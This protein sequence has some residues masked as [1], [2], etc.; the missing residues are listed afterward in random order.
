MCMVRIEFVIPVLFARGSPENG[1]LIRVYCS[2]H[3]NEVVN[4]MRTFKS[5]MLAGI[6]AVALAGAFVAPGIASAEAAGPLGSLGSLGSEPEATESGTQV[7]TSDNNFKL[8]A[9]GYNN[10]TVEFTLE[11]LRASGNTPNWRADYRVD[12]EDPSMEREIRD[13]YRPVLTNSQETY[14]AIEKRDNS[15]DIDLN[16]VTIDLTADRTV[17]VDNTD[18]AIAPGVAPNADGVHEVTFGV[19]QGPGLGNDQPEYNAQK[20][21]TVTGCPTE[22]PLGSLGSLDVFGSIEG[23]FSTEQ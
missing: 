18:V 19:Y 20:T 14:D 7:I 15:Y 16:E 23:L 21:V 4:H 22:S 3:Q 11:N 12:G 6:G 10:C 8:S 5:S 9:T 1:L 2:A 17:P 13:V